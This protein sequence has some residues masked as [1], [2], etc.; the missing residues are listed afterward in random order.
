MTT[1]AAPRKGDTVTVT[2]NGRTWAGTWTVESYRA[3]NRA[4]V[5]RDDL[6]HVVSRDDLTVAGA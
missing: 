5:A 4:V 6:R 3:G 2:E 1:T